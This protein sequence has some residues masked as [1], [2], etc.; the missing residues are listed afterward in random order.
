MDY[1]DVL[2]AAIEAVLDWDLP[3]E[4]C[5]DAIASRAAMLS[6]AMPENLTA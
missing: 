6:G 1:D 2:T 5:N 4:V 3:D